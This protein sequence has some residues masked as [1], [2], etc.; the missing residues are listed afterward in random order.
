MEKV[1]IYLEYVIVF[2]KTY[3]ENLSHLEE[4]LTN[5][6]KYGV[7]LQIRKR[8]FITDLIKYFSHIIRSGNLEV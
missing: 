1:L 5:L 7:T 4:V 2:S 8:E 6:I 3:N